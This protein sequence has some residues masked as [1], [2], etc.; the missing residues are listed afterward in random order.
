MVSAVASVGFVIVILLTGADMWQSMMAQGFADAREDVNMLIQ[1]DWQRKD[2]QDM[3]E[4]AERAS[5]RAWDRNY[6]AQKEFAQHGIQ[7]RVSDAQAAGLHPVFA[8]GGGGA[9]FAPSASVAVASPSGVPS[10][11]SGSFSSMGQNL[12]RASKAEMTEEQRRF[13]ELQ[14]LAVVAQIH[15]RDSAAD[16]NAARAEQIRRQSNAS[17]G[18]GSSDP[19][20]AV[21][22][23]AVGGNS[24][25]GLIQVQPDQPTSYASSDHA[26]TAAKRPAWSIF[27]VHS[28]P[29]GEWVL[30]HANSGSEAFESIG[31]GIAPLWLTI[32][33]NMARD[34]DFL[35]KNKRYI[36]FYDEISGAQDFLNELGGSLGRA[37]AAGLEAR[38]SSGVRR[39]PYIREDYR[40][41]NKR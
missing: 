19:N 6:A 20:V 34:P 41:S 11:G 10:G 30:P 24:G 7:W 35:R 13:Q 29:G 23:P 4:D 16:L 3:R 27:R 37:I 31:E 32:R 9:A 14:E 18:L 28:G 1:R 12:A 21:G 38:P 26:V 15:E 40:W 17:N 39:R 22:L 25:A 8:L 33:E 36:P 5:E 2:F